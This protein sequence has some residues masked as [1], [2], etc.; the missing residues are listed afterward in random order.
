MVLPCHGLNHIYLIDL[1]MSLLIILHLLRQLLLMV[2][3]KV[4]YLVLYCLF[5]MFLSSQKLFLLTILTHYPMQMIDSHLYVSFDQTSLNTAMISI[6]SCLSSIENWSSSMSLKLNPSKFELI[7]LD[8]VRAVSWH[9]RGRQPLRAP[10]F[11]GA[12]F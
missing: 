9:R 3:H 4:L 5:F 2:Y 7:C 8:R 12:K 1:S 11:R 10:D 6:S